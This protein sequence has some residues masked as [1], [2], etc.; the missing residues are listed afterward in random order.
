MLCNMIHANIMC[1]IVFTCQARAGPRT[2]ANRAWSTPNAR[3]T[4]FRA[5]SCR[6]ANS[7]LFSPCGIGIVLTNVADKCQKVV[8]FHTQLRQLSTCFQRFL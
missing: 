1:F 8:K 5:D 6:W 7:F 2:I 3:S 4:S